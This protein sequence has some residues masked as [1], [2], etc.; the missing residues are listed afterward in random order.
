MTAAWAEGSHRAP[1]LAEVL[2]VL[3]AGKPRML[4]YADAPVPESAPGPVRF[5]DAPLDE[6]VRVIPRASL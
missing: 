6:A 4:G 1:E 5:C 3:E 2:R